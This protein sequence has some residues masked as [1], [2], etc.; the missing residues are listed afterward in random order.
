MWF[1][2][3]FGW[4]ST[5]SHRKLLSSSHFSV[6]PFQTTN[7]NSLISLASIPTKQTYHALN[8]TLK[9]FLSTKQKSAYLCLME[10]AFILWHSWKY[11]CSLLSHKFLLAIGKQ[12][13]NNDKWT[14]T[15]NGICLLLQNKKHTKQHHKNRNKN[16]P[17]ICFAKSSSL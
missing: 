6:I 15:T 16:C 12:T 10:M 1:P 3:L 5:V 2:S 7:L 11:T 8:F 14:I 17:L 13:S 9:A 4:L